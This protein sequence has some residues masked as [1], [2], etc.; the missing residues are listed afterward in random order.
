MTGARSMTGF[1]DAKAEEG[2]FS[3]SV[4]IRSVNHRSLDLK[5]RV[6]AKAGR[7]EQ[8]IRGMIR[9]RL[10]RGSIQ[11]TIEQRFDGPLVSRIDRELVRARIEALREVAELCG[12][13]TRPDPNLVLGLPGSLVS[14]EREMS[15]DKLE[16]LVSAALDHALRE[17]DLARAVE[18]QALIADIGEHTG[19][20]E[21]EVH[22]IRSSVGLAVERRQA[23]VAQRIDE[24][25]T[26]SGL[27]PGRLAQEAALIASRADI[28]EELSRLQA[29]VDALRVCLEGRSEIGKRIDFLAQEMNRE[30]N[31]LLSKAQVLG[32][33]GLSLTE[34]GLRIREGIE[35]IR[36][37]ALNLE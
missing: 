37:Q 7:L 27:E 20:I 32:E 2:G 35:K 9:E 23:I 31:T 25:L 33:T 4:T 6:P 34:A 11:V 36:E 8:H 15:D 16:S 13:D 1:A 17:L 21:V 10:R 28:S 3:V 24:L 5:L 14:D 26:G 18:G 29:H 30:A 19:R 12:V 22:R